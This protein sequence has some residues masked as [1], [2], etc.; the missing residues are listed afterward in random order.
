VRSTTAADMRRGDSMAVGLLWGSIIF[1]AIII[2]MWASRNLYP[3]QADLSMIDEDLQA[4]SKITSEACNSY[5]YE[6]RYNPKVEQ[7]NLTFD[8]FSI[9]IRTERSSMCSYSIC[10][11]GLD[12]LLDLSTITYVTIAK[13]R[14]D[15][16][17]YA[18][19][20]S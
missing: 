10:D 1:M 20:G 11:L 15:G 18:I 13:T 7:G 14:D 6:R 5:T 2:S 19:T 3:V 4:L 12:E 9:C 8:G 17:S 16:G